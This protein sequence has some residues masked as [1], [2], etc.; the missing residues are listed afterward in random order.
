M[1]Y[2]LTRDFIN[3]LISIRP[4]AM[5]SLDLGKTFPASAKATDDMPSTEGNHTVVKAG[6]APLLPTHNKI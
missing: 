1:A 5:T 6:N 2:K 4:A 3:L